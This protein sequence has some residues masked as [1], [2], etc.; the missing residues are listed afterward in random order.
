MINEASYEQVAAVFEDFKSR[1]PRGGVI[2]PD[3]KPHYST[4]PFNAN[5]PLPPYYHVEMSFNGEQRRY[6][7]MALSRL[8]MLAEGRV[9]ES[10]D[11]SVPT[12]AERVEAHF[13]ED[14]PPSFQ[15]AILNSS[16]DLLSEFRDRFP[17]FIPALGGIFRVAGAE[18]INAVIGYSTEDLKFDEDIV[19]TFEVQKS[20]FVEYH[21]HGEMEYEVL[22]SGE[23]FAKILMRQTKQAAVNL[24][25]RGVRNGGKHISD[26]NTIS[27]L[28]SHVQLLAAETALAH[29]RGE[30]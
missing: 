28:K 8:G 24:V 15:T 9:F 11:V 3:K 19:N 26:S 10:D 12:F 13:L 23:G 17:V 20:N 2:R 29:S 4:N 30:V 18:G 21:N 5:Q 16:L 1:D 14:E 27:K 22:C 6:I 25:Q 7:V